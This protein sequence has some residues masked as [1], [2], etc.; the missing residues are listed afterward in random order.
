MPAL[1]YIDPLK[2]KKLITQLLDADYQA[3][4]R[5]T[6]GAI[7]RA[8]NDPALQKALKALEIESRQLQMN[9]QKLTPDNAYVKALL[10][11][12]DTMLKNQQAALQGGAVDVM[13]S[14]IKAAEDISFNLSFPGMTPNQVEKL[15]YVW[16]TPDPEAVMKMTRYMVGPAWDDEVRKWGQTFSQDF[17]DIILR[18]FTAG[19][20]PKQTARD[21]RRLVTDMPQYKANNLLRTLQINSYR[22]A[23]SAHRQVNAAIVEYHIRMAVLDQRVCIACVLLHGTKLLINQD[24]KDHWSGRCF[25]INKIKGMPDRNIEAGEDWLKRQP[26]DL[27]AKL[28][29]KAAFNAWKGG[30][31]QLTDLIGYKSDPI[32]GSMPVVRSLK[33]ILGEATAKQYY[34]GFKGEAIDPH[35]EIKTL[36]QRIQP[37]ADNVALQII[38]AVDK[39]KP[40]EDELRAVQKEY[41]RLS[42]EL[43]NERSS[44]NNSIFNDPNKQ[45]YAFFKK[46]SEDRIAKLQAEFQKASTDWSKL[47]K[48]VKSRA[49][50]AAD[51]IGKGTKKAGFVHA[52]LGRQPGFSADETKDIKANMKTAKDWL[53][54]AF[55]GDVYDR[56]PYSVDYKALRDRAYHSGGWIYI[57]VPDGPNIHIHEHGHF[58]EYMRPEVLDRSKQ[59]RDYRNGSGPVVKL[60]DLFPTHNYEDDEITVVDNWKHPYTGKIYKHNSTEILSMGIQYMYEDPVDF[61]NSDPEFFAY[62]YA[63]M[64]GDLK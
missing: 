1:N 53:N 62:V 27:Q 47:E 13:E 5:M 35:I 45:G 61:Y 17:N 25:S 12:V 23:D 20:G 21:L 15:G 34:A 41:W 22:K 18:G 42:K 28:M 49:E 33:G 24:V 19:Q 10:A 60:K 44:W 29:G 14:G 6:L 36:L 51:I 54:K 4:A 38:N 31:I 48:K 39:Q 30:R 16:N 50:I 57:D 55:N 52:P 63:V 7:A 43:Q 58:I 9:R 37:E 2:L 59:F 46:V 3:A 8:S 26:P 64:K 11:E 32:F 56:F 40:L